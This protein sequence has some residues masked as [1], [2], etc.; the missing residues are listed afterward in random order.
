M[1]KSSTDQL[2]E[3]F[4]NETKNYRCKYF[5]VLVEKYVKT[6]HLSDEYDIKTL[7]VVKDKGCLS[8]IKGSKEFGTVS[9]Y[10]CKSGRE[11]IKQWKK[12]LIV[13]RKYGLRKYTVEEASSEDDYQSLSSD[14][15]AKSFA[16]DKN[17]ESFTSHEETESS[18]SN[19]EVKSYAGSFIS[20]EDAESFTSHEETESSTSD[21][22][23]ARA[24]SKSVR[25]H[26]P[27]IKKAKSCDDRQ[28]IPSNKDY[29]SFPSDDEI[30]LLSHKNCKPKSKQRKECRTVDVVV[31][32]S[33]HEKQYLTADEEQQSTNPPE[34][35]DCCV[36]LVK[37]NINAYNKTSGPLSTKN[38]FPKEVKSCG[39]SRSGK[40]FC[41]SP[42]K[43]LMPVSKPCSNLFDPSDSI[44]KNPDRNTNFRVE[45]KS[46]NKLKKAKGLKSNI[47]Q[48]KIICKEQIINAI[49][50]LIKDPENDFKC[51]FSNNKIKPLPCAPAVTSI[52]KKFSFSSIGIGTH[53]T[54]HRDSKKLYPFQNDSSLSSWGC[55]LKQ[56][57]L[58]F[59]LTKSNKIKEKSH[60]VHHEENVLLDSLSQEKTLKERKRFTSYALNTLPRNYLLALKEQVSA[61][62][63]REKISQL[64]CPT[65]GDDKS[66]ATR[67]CIL[68]SPF[69]DED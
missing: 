13:Q 32:S 56:S 26:L 29:Q 4:I 5:E 55:E 43:T 31:L 18:T 6:Q 68:K 59:K 27:S 51:A 14:E 20:D 17:T 23:E 46:K 44:F 21:E 54:N 22:I 42:N 12:N 67:R 37:L 41:P 39:T 47:K 9:T 2:F 24:P 57:I 48:P 63:V 65:N 33:D 60:A 1:P 53:E 15:E 62:R 34:I 30:A 52:P 35:T 28:R 19:E 38:D 69:L 11:T 7:K 45:F 64:N 25:K 40:S 66:P 49:L 16:S 61:S 8:K 58:P 10:Y 50:S 3:Q 36:K